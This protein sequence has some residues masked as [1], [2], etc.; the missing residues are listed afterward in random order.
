MAHRLLIVDDDLAQRRLFSAILQLR[1]Y[2][3][4]QAACESETLELLHQHEVDVVVMDLWL[5]SIPDTQDE[6][7]LLRAIKQHDPELECII[8]TG[9]AT[10]KTAIQAINLGAYSYLLKPCEQS[11]FELTVQHALE[12]RQAQRELRREKESLARRV[13]ERTAELERLNAQ[14]ARSARAKDEWLANMSHELRTPLNSILGLAE[15]LLEQTYGTINE[16]QQHYLES[17]TDSGQ[18]LL[19]LITDI[20]DIAKIEADRFDLFMEM[21]DIQ[22]V[23]ES[24]L[25]MLNQA[26]H[27]KHL[28]LSMQVATVARQVYADERRLK[29]ILVNLLSNAVKFT[30]EQG[31]IGLNVQVS[32][33]QLWIELTIW[34]TGIGIGEE[35]ILQIFEP[36]TQLDSGLSRQYTGTGLGLTLVRKLTG[37][38]G[39]KI[40]VQSQPKHGSRFTICLPYRAALPAHTERPGIHLAPVQVVA[41]PMDYSV[42]RNG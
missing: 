15:T 35:E 12:K 36:F 34:D 10:Q 13:A 18:H 6:L 41:L 37:L 42:Q 19:Y 27:K 21:V 33:D 24:A 22:S 2:E 4:L 5:A 29:Q 30:P 25:R 20:L 11:Q 16:R 1:G 9:H 31:E 28:H 14:L 26:A 38:L 40:L 32:A 3:C 23:G 39:G 17:I 8:L 7:S